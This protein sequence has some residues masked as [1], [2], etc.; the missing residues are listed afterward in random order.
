MLLGWEMWFS[1]KPIIWH[2]LNV[3]GYPK[4]ACFP[5]T[6]ILLPSPVIPVF[7]ICLSVSQVVVWLLMPNR[8]SFCSFLK[9]LNYSGTEVFSPLRPSV[10][11]LCLREKNVG[12]LRLYSSLSP[13]TVI[14]NMQPVSLYQQFCFIKAKPAD[15]RF[16]T[17][18]S[19]HVVGLHVYNI[20]IVLPYMGAWTVSSIW[21]L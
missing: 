21:I 9:F 14:H 16:Y 18:C 10:N 4:Q 15:E 6:N 20:I 1:F 19:Q 8:F 5:L 11:I 17:C 7:F 3:D 12:L 13:S 2:W